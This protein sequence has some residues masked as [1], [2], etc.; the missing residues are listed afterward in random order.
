MSF[1]YTNK[2]SFSLCMRK[3]KPYSLMLKAFGILV[4]SY[5]P[6]PITLT[7]LDFSLNKY[8]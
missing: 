8:A 5:L 2:S 7:G 4:L 1:P 6:K 3:S